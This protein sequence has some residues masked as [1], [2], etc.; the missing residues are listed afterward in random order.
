MQDVTGASRCL[1]RLL[2]LTA[3]SLLLELW[4]VVLKIA[5]LIHSFR[6]QPQSPDAMFRFETELSQ[7]LTEAG[8]RIVRW[9]LNHL[10]PNDPARLPKQLFWEGD[11]YRLKRRSPTRNLNCL[12]GK[13]RV[14]RW[15]YEPTED[16][17][18]PCLFPLELKLGLLQRLATPALF[19]RVAQL[20]VDYADRQLLDILRAEHQVTWG[21]GTLKKVTDA[22]ANRMGPFRHEAQVERVLGWLQQAAGA[23]G[24]RKIVLSVG[25]DGIMLP[26]RQA[27]KYR[28]GAAATVS[29][30]DR[31]GKRLGTVYL[32]QMPEAQQVTISE[33]LTR[34]IQDVLAAWQGPSLRLV[35]VT[36]AGFHPSEYFAK[37]LSRLPNPHRPGTYYQWEWVVDY[38][39]ACQYI[40]QLGE[41][42]FGKGRA[43]QGW[44]AKMRRVLRDKPS[45]IFRVLRSAGALRT[46]RNLAGKESDYQTAYAYLRNHAKFMDY[47]TYRQLKTPIGS[48]ITEA[49][50]KILFT[51]RIKRAGM[52]WD[53]DGG[54]PVV[55]LRAIALSG[56]WSAARSAMLK[57]MYKTQPRTPNAYHDDSAKIAA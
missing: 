45:G 50:C 49:A 17:G 3:P 2:E 36:D 8:R 35:Y 18:L 30:M 6:S 13:I 23:S 10:E 25:R 19:D 44:S 52:K 54:K 53:I 27:K 34:L 28:E 37:V 15:L 5:R 38:Y 7:L 29:V 16:L 47:R 31:W 32:G 14:W 55:A 24:P 43:A 21:V 1:A 56:V 12:F 46:I 57:S 20:T 42:I 11:H 9:T 33:E 26:I 22:V 40:S 51:Q 4:A 48:G 41:V 39:H